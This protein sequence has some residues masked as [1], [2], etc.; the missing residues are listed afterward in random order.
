MQAE[1]QAAAA[2]QELT[3]GQ[4]GVTV[5]IGGR[6]Y[7]QE[8]L[9]I[10]QAAK[11]GHRFLVLISEGME[12]GTIDQKAIEAIDLENTGTIWPVL[13]KVGAVLP[14]LLGELFAAVLVVPE[15][16]DGL[17]EQN[18][19]HVRRHLKVRQAMAMLGTFVE[20]NDLADV[21]T[22]FFSTRDAVSR[23]LEALSSKAD[24][25]AKPEDTSSTEEKSSPS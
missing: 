13:A 11:V 10:E 8:E 20:Q 17:D 2:V 1:V 19:L 21:V 7:L 9:G 15:T 24:V 22:S 12:S 16:Y 6:P 25:S 3:D 23:G 14:E 18:V 5:E 4:P